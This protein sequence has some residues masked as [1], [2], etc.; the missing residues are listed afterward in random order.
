[1]VTDASNSKYG[2]KYCYIPKKFVP[3]EKNHR[4]P[5]SQTLSV[6][7]DSKDICVVVLLRY[8]YIESECVRMRIDAF[9]IKHY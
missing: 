5:L 7:Y 3:N 1:M 4:I 6:Y 8:S 9:L 2:D